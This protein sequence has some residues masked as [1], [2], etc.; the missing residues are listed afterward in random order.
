MNVFSDADLM[1]FHAEYDEMG[2]DK[3]DALIARLEA[4]EAYIE[5]SHPRGAGEQSG[6]A[7][8]FYKVW[9]Q[10]AGKS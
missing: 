9:R 8:D 10:A 2:A 4:A 1:R 3:I 7:F 5:F 6:D